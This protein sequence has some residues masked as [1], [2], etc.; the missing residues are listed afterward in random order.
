MNGLR[1]SIHCNTSSIDGLQIPINLIMSPRD[2]GKTTCFLERVHRIWKASGKVGIASVR[3]VKQVDQCLVD[4]WA[5]KMNSFLP[6]SE[7][8]VLQIA[9]GVKGKGYGPIIEK[10]AKKPILFVIALNNRITTLKNIVVPNPSIWWQDETI[11]DPTTGEK[12]LPN[13]VQHFREAFNTQLRNTDYKLR[14]YLCG[15]PYSL[16]NP[17]IAEYGI[18]TYGMSLDEWRISEDRQFLFWWKRLHPELEA[19]LKEH[20]PLY[21]GKDDRY[22][23]YALYGE[24]INDENAFLLPAIP[25]GFQLL[26]YFKMLDRYFGIYQGDGDGFRFYVSEVADFPSGKRSI[27]TFDLLSVSRGV[28]LVSFRDKAKFALLKQAIRFNEVAYQTLTCYYSIVE[29]FPNI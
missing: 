6:S 1:D 12:Y 29:V 25:K 23:R 26:F 3:N 19:Y 2:D 16:Y 28:T 10:N 22:V 4:S 14:A 11:I 27:F 13:E 8:M 18:S 20:N 21:K 17:Y 24:P 9:P 15:N 5:Y 7:K